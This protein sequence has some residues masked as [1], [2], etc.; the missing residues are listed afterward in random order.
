MKLTQLP[1]CAE[2]REGEWRLFTSYQYELQRSGNMIQQI[3]DGSVDT[4]CFDQVIVIQD[5]GHDV[6]LAKLIDDLRN[7]RFDIPLAGRNPDLDS[8]RLQ[9]G[10]HP[11]HKTDRVIVI[12][13]QRQLGN[14]GIAVCKPFKRERSLS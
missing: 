6:K 14:V 11:V 10:D 4:L 7:D 1:A 8:Y 3:G 13:I 12:F 9:G 2:A 5:E